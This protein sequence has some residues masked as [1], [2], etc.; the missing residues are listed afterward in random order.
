[1]GGGTCYNGGWLPPGMAIPGGTASSQPPTSPAPPDPPV[2]L[3]TA[4][5]TP[6]PFVG[7]GGGSCYQGGWL[8]PGFAV[9]VTGTL[10]VMDLEAGLWNFEAADGTIFTSVSEL[11][12][13]QL[14]DGALVTLHGL[15]LPSGDSTDDVIVVEILLI[16]IHD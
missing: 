11:A 2:A 7:L 12:A 6:D 13:D 10:H 8:P 15:T 4:C 3:N 5:S 14:I 16:E 9:T 1:M